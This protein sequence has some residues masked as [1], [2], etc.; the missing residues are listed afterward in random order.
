MHHRRF[1]RYYSI[2]NIC[3]VECVDKRH[4][5]SYNWIMSDI[6]NFTYSPEKNLKLISE[7]N[8]SFDE[9]IAAIDNGQ[10]IDILDHPNQSRYSNQ[11]IY[12]IYAKDYV[13]LVP[14]VKDKNNMIFLKTIIPSRKAKDMY[15][16][17]K[18]AQQK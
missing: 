13:Y 11:K 15:V 18:K 14:F 4:T 10:V 1:Q 12:V 9:I 6:P 16:N 8:I 7:R 5:L 17:N 2:K 3:A